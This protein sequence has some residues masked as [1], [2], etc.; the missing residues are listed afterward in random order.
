MNDMPLDPDQ[1]R[2]E[3]WKALVDRLGMAGAVRFLQLIGGTSGDYTAERAS[4]LKDDDL[5]SIRAR[6]E[7]RRSTPSTD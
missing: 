2:E 5:A 3:A 7:A 6:V 1:L 4:W